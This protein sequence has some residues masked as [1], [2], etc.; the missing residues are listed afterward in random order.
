MPRSAASEA[1]L[2]IVVLVISA[3]TASSGAGP[4]LIV[5]PVDLDDG[6]ASP[7]M[8]ALEALLDFETAPLTSKGDDQLDFLEEAFADWR[9]GLEPDLSPFFDEWGASLG[10]TDGARLP[11]TPSLVP[12][13]L[14]LIHLSRVRIV[15]R[16]ARLSDPVYRRGPRPLVGLARRD[17]SCHPVHRDVG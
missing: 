2:S 10:P 3:C 14:A 11:E 12:E 7:T 6:A 13:G 5:I 17:T 4:E 1:A 15:E 8:E 16:L 9:A